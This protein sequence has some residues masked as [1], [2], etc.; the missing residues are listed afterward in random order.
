MR[1]NW[2][3]IILYTIKPFCGDFRGE[4]AEEFIDEIYELSEKIKDMRTPGFTYDEETEEYVREKDERTVLF[5]EFLK[6]H[7]WLNRTIAGRMTEY[8]DS[9]VSNVFSKNVSSIYTRLKNISFNV[10]EH[11]DL[12]MTSISELL[13]TKGA[14]ANPKYKSSGKEVRM[15]SDEYFDEFIRLFDLLNDLREDDRIMYNL[16]KMSVR[17]YLNGL[18]Y[19][20]MTGKEPET[21]NIIDVILPAMEYIS[22]VE[23]VQQDEKSGIYEILTD[24]YENDKEFI[25]KLAGSDVSSLFKDFKADSVAKALDK[26]QSV[27]VKNNIL[28][29]Y[30]DTLL[31]DKDI[32]ADKLSELKDA[33]GQDEI[34][35]SVAL[36]CAASPYDFGITEPVKMKELYDAVAEVCDGV[37]KK[38]MNYVF[39]IEQNIVNTDAILKDDFYLNE[40]LV[41]SMPDCIDKWKSFIDSD[42]YRSDLFGKPMDDACREIA[43]KILSNRKKFGLI[44]KKE[45]SDIIKGF[46]QTVQRR[47]YVVFCMVAVIAVHQEIL[48]GTVQRQTGRQDVQ[49]DWQQLLQC[50]MRSYIFEGRK[51]KGV[52]RRRRQRTGVRGHSDIRGEVICQVLQ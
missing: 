51:H 16:F 1:N 50:S 34:T 17:M 25:T 43:G 41:I 23:R 10:A 39:S 44:N 5:V 46:Q 33:T 40:K 22:N 8:M 47:S 9:N 24:D 2:F 31:E 13:G 6:K 26:I 42:M 38:L 15:V 14:A 21:Y 18:S 3:D 49:R 4:N 11:R 32:C 52:L 36:E 27:Y 48:P 12:Y 45:C 19:K 28:I 35:P 30:L 29:S 20:L 37:L 7:G